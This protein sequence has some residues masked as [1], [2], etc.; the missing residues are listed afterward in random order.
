MVSAPVSKGAPQ[1]ASS[2][3]VCALFAGALVGAVFVTCGLLLSWVGVATH[4]AWDLFAIGYLWGFIAA[5]VGLVSD[6]G[7]RSDQSETAGG[8]SRVRRC[9][10]GRAQQLER[11]R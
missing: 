4:D 2:P 10:W 5:V 1:V 3:L 11:M 9:R 8:E 6:R 7:G